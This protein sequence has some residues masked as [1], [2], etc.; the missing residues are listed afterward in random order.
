MKFVEEM[1]QQ[2]IYPTLDRAQALRDLDPVEAENR[3]LMTCPQC[4]MRTARIYKTGVILVCEC[5]YFR[6]IFTLVKERHHLDDK[7]AY[8]KLSCMIN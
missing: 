3:F 4:G 6:D 1:L 5:G 7:K 2:Q 8:E